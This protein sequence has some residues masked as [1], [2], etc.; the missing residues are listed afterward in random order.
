MYVVDMSGTDPR[1]ALVALAE[2]HGESLARLSRLI[3]RN[4]A[5]LQQYVRRGTPRRLPEEER[6]TLA[7]Y[8][9]VE[10]SEFGGPETPLSKPAVAVAKLSVGASAGPGAMPEDD[11]AAI[12]FPPDLLKA[13]GVQGRRLSMIQASGDSMEPTL[14]DGDWMLVDHD[15]PLPHARPEICVARIEGAVA[16]KRL[17]RRQGQVRVVSDNP[18]YPERLLAAEEVEIIGR[19]VWLGRSV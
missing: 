17:A 18:A 8:F 15:A 19:V 5:Y 6:R 11:A 14:H 12:P 2:R 1:A 7:R 10:E 13:F 3:G 4:E 9:R 16:V